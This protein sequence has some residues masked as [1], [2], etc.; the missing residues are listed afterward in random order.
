MLSSNPHAVLS[1]FDTEQQETKIQGP[2]RHD[3]VPMEA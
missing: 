2:M 1:E 3:L